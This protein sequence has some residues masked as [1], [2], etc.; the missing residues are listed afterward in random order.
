M[1]KSEKQAVLNVL[2]TYKNDYNYY[3]HRDTN[4]F[5][6]RTEIRLQISAIREVMIALNIEEEAKEHV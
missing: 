3:L 5:K 2:R 1:T 4:L 6:E